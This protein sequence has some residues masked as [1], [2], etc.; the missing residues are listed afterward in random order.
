MIAAN[1][2]V[3]GCSRAARCRRST[4]STSA[5]S[6]ARVERLVEQL[7]SLDVPTPPLPEAISPAAGGRPRGRDLAPGR[8]ARAAH[9]PGRAAL[10]SL[11]LRSLEAGALL[12]REPRPPRA[13]LA[14]LLPLHVADPPLSRPRLPPG[15][16]VGGRRRRGGAARRP[17][18]RRPAT[19]ARTASAARRTSS[20][21]PTTSRAASCSRASCSS[22]AGDAEWRRR[23]RRRDRRRRVRRVRRGP[24]GA[25]AG[26]PPA[27]RLVGAR[28]ARDEAASARSRARRSGSA[29]RSSSRSSASTRR[30]GAST[31]PP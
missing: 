19:G 13:A 4:A 7:A 16:A 3:A 27:R 31:S 25:A 20:A 26:A 2:A 11:V 9:R 30:A 6:P 28:R 12:A 5:P 1:E 29:T 18:S 24:R 21:R 23:G 10:T 22:A 17:T 8:R 15:A 14:A